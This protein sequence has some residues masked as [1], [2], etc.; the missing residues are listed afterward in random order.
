MEWY[1][2]CEKLFIHSFIH[3]FLQVT[4]HWA[5]WDSISRRGGRTWIWNSNQI[6][7]YNQFYRKR[8]LDNN[9]WRHLSI[10]FG[11]ALLASKLLLIVFFSLFSLTVKMIKSQYRLRGISCEKVNWDQE[12][13]PQSWS[14]HV[15][16]QTVPEVHAPHLQD[17]LPVCLFPLYK[18]S[19]LP[20]DLGAWFLISLR[21][22]EEPRA[23]GGGVTF[24]LMLCCPW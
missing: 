11:N 12:G 4:T 24:S 16:A 10:G 14:L 21:K 19:T 22:M 7:G 9:H 1:N 18:P 3:P 17:V 13:A 15:N 6:Q 2:A 20:E 8:E 5:L 23:R